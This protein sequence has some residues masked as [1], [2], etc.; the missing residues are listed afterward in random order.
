MLFPPPYLS[1]IFQIFLQQ[2]PVELT[3]VNVKKY[4]KKWKISTHKLRK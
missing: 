3:R 4:I 1:A 2:I